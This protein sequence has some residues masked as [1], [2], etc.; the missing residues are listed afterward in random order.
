[1][2]F[3]RIPAGPYSTAAVWVSEM[4]PA[5]VAAYSPHVTKPR[6]AVIEERLTIA[7]PRF[8][9]AAASLMPNWQPRICTRQNRSDLATSASASMWP[10]A[11]PALLTM[12]SRPPNRLT[13]SSHRAAICFGSPTSVFLNSHPHAAACSLTSWISA[14]STFAPAARRRC[15]TAAPIPEPPPVTMADLP[16]S[17]NMFFST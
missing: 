4:M 7:P 11:I 13:A 1:M 9:L 17:L 3:T 2:Q 10:D 16:L 12:M 15:A 5:L 8:I 6:T 14:T